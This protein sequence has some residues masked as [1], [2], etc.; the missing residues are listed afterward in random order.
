[1]PYGI[2]IVF[3]GVT[4]K[5]YWAVNDALGIPRDDWTQ[6]WP[7]GLISHSGGATATGWVVTEVWES[8]A[9]QERFM[10]D[11]LGPSLGAVG[12]PDPVQVIESD[13]VSVQN[14]AK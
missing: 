8:K 14:A 10:A 5:D 13:L 3:E 4:E 11:R 12:V 6:G 7:E 1:M 2:V 9:E